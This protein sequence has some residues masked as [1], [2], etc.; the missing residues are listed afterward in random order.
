MAEPNEHIPGL[1][2]LGENSKPK[3]GRPPK[4]DKTV[5]RRGRSITVSVTL[6]GEVA[7]WAKAE[8]DGNFRTI[9]GQITYCVSLAMKDAK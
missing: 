4:A 7:K 2:E 1:G 8:A 6:T 9:E 5:R 3:R